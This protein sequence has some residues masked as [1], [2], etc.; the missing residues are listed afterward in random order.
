MRSAGGIEGD[1][2]AAHGLFEASWQRLEALTIEHLSAG[3][4]AITAQLEDR[5]LACMPEVEDAG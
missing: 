3:G 5:L 4:G 2:R 1:I